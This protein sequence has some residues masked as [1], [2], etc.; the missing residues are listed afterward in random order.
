MNPFL[1]KLGLSAN[2][3]AVVLHADDIGSTQATIPAYK[4][5][6]TRGSISA[7][8]VMVPCPWFP[9]AAQ[10]FRETAELPQADVGVHL[11]HT[12][13]W[14]AF[15]WGPITPAGRDP[16]NGLLDPAGYFHRQTEPVQTTGNADTVTAE[17]EGQIERAL[18]LNGA[19]IDVTHIDTHMGTMMH[20]RFLPSYVAT[21]F[22]YRVPVFAIRL[23]TEL[24]LKNGYDEET[25]KQWVANSEM[26]EAQGMPLFNGYSMLPLR[27]KTAFKDR[28][29]HGRRTL[30]E[31]P[32]GLYYFIIHPAVD[33][34]ELR[35]TAP[36]WE[37][38]V[39]DYT[40][41]MSDT[42]Q[43][44]VEAS[45]VNVVSMRQLRDVMRA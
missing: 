4:D 20:P 36:D 13:E 9:A 43:K 33:S 22:K 10:A 35:G 6:V 15:R 12:S 21:G 30:E 7:A 23:T 11:T 18:D 27:E 16:Q 3:K 5:L 31:A 14:E 37:A 24:L 34:P 40:L 1:K 44:T 42:W 39:M 45:G 29:E 32:A 38:R 17:M 25:A 8:S 26:V 2:S 28:L 19:G 41:F